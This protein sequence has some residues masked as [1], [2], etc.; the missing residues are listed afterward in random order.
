MNKVKI[1]LIGG[2]FQH[3]YSS[4]GWHHPKLI[5]WDKSGNANMSIYI[6]DAMMLVP[7]KNKKNYAWFLESSSICQN[8]FDWIPNNIS[9]LEDNFDLIFT[10][11]KRLLPLSSKFKIVLPPAV[12]WIDDRGIHNK[13]KLISMIVSNKKMCKGHVYRQQVLQKYRNNIDCFGSG[14]NRIDKKEKGLNDYYFSV[15]IQNENYPNYFTEIVTDCFATGTIPIFG[16]TSAISEY[17]DERGII[18]FTD[19]FKVD[20]LSTDLYYSKME[21]IKDNFER[22]CDLPIAEDYIFKTYLK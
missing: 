19:D 21:Y 12:P 14:H 13:T 8:L 15:A 4:Y 2:G 11:D 20:D 16:G 5:E 17:F 3:A 6:D 10:Y 1:N 18:F 7:N 9:Q 22:V